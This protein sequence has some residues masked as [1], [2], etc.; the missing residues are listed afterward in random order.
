MLDTV[1]FSIDANVS[2]PAPSGIAPPVIVVVLPLSSMLASSL[3]LLA[4]LIVWAVMP[5]CPLPPAVSSK[6]LALW[7]LVSSP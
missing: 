7:V 5:S 2:F 4:S 1:R 6:I 3:A